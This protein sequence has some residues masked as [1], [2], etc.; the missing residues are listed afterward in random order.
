MATVTSGRRI[1]VSANS[2]VLGVGGRLGMGVAVDACEHLVVSGIGMAV[3]AGS[4]DLGMG[5]GVDGELAMGESG[6]GPGGS[7]VTIG[8]G[9]GESGRRVVG[10]VGGGVLGLMAGG[11]VRRRGRENVVDVGGSVGGYV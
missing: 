10:V 2:L 9:C 1:N 8:A 4:P 5:A 6:A 3:P 7:G 11:A